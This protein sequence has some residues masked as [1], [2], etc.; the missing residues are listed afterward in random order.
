VVLGGGLLGLKPPTAW[1]K[2][3]DVTVIHNHEV[4]LNRQMDRQ[5]AKMLQAELEQRGLKFRLAA[6][7]KQL[8][9]DENGHITGKF[10]NGSKL[11][12]DLFVMAI[13]CAPI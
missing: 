6:N 3:M 4:L 12:C 13:G 7:V 11:E 8:L 5:S 10:D 1:F 2:G 9:G